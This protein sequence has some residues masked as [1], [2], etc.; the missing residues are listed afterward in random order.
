MVNTAHYF[1]GEATCDMARNGQLLYRDYNHLNINGSRFLARRV[2]DDY[3]SFDAA[4]GGIRA[5]G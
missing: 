5:A 4:V 2:I 3:P 1:C